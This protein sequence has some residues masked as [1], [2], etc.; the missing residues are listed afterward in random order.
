MKKYNEGTKI[1]IKDLLLLKDKVIMCGMP[2]YKYILMGI[3]IVEKFVLENNPSN[4]DNETIDNI[5][6]EIKKNIEN[7]S[8]GYI[9]Y[10]IFTGIKM[11]YNNI[12][13]KKTKELKK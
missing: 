5:L 3:D 12:E 4:I 6:F 2:D 9:N 8:L 7:N 11:G 13:K 1:I 10:G